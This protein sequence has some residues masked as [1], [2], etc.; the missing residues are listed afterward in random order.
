MTGDLF[1][2]R[3]TDSIF[4]EDHFPALGGQMYHKDQC[5]EIDWN[6]KSM[7]FSD[8]CTMETERQVQRLLDLQNIANNLPD[9][10]TNYKGVVKS[11]NSSRNVPERV[12][13]PKKTTQIIPPESKRGRGNSQMQDKK[14]K[15]VVNEGQFFVDANFVG[16]QY[17]LERFELIPSPLMC[18]DFEAWTSNDPRSIVLGNHDDL[19]RVDE[20]AINYIETG[21]SYD[22][23]NTKVE[24]FFSE[25]IAEVLRTDP[26]PKSMAECMKCL[27]WNKWKEAIETE[28]ASLTKR[29]VFSDVLLK[30]SN[31][32]PVGFKWVFIGK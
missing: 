10:F 7:S 9:A 1:T 20:I 13:V 23:S 24:I 11:F 19:T 25:Q 8:A 3:F 15:Q 29:E 28:I 30:P 16:N 31:V 4:D 32:N 18:T 27:D 26:D 6:A 14:Q 21:E 12:E 17:L 22:R 5:R 2:A